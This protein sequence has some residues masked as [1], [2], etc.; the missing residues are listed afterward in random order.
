VFDAWKRTAAP[1][2]ARSLDGDPPPFTS[3]CDR[4]HA[5][6]GGLLASLGIEP[7]ATGWADCRRDAHRRAQAYDDVAPALELL[8]ANGLKVAVLS[9]ADDDHLLD[10]IENNGLSFDAVVSSEQLRW[11]KPHRTTFAV[12]CAQLGVEPKEAAYVGD[13]PFADVVGS[14][15]AGMQAIWINRNNKTWPADLDA[16]DHTITTLLDLPPLIRLPR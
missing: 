11:Y 6:G 10:C 12:I 8:R 13:S 7:D 3:L 1:D 9:D 5:H 14:R 15:M 4:W 2:L 16:P